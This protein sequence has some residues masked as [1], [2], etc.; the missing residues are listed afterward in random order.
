MSRDGPTGARARFLAA[1]EGTAHGSDGA[2]RLCTACVLALPVQRAGMMISVPDVGLEVLSASDRVAERTEWLQ[3]TLSQGPAVDASAR[4]VPISVPDLNEANGRWPIFLSEVADSGIG[5]MYA[6]P[7]QI[8]AIKVGVLDLY[9]TAE[10]PL[11]AAEFAEAV[12]IS[13]LVTAVLLN[14]DRDGHLPDSLGPWWNQPPST[15]E[16]HQATGMVMAQLGLDARSAYVRLQ[17]IAFESGR[18]LQEVAADVVSRR[19]RLRRDP[20]DNSGPEQ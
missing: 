2:N 19:E 11:G 17:A 14:V 8:G 5:G 16:V 15:R 1:V 20:A 10:A 18:L 12:A 4:S 6:L 9:C 13:E 3:V 7:L